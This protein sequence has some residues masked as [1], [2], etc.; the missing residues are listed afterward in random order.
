MNPLVNRISGN[1]WI[2]PVSAMSLV[3]GFMVAL[4]WVTDQ[5]RSSRLNFVSTSQ[6][7]RVQNQAVDMQD[8]VTS[9]QAEVAK[10]RQENTR[11]QNAVGKQNQS[12]RMLNES[13][14]EMK[15]LAGLTDLEGPGV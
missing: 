15:I 14:Q 3:L 10:L 8:A 1:A 2:M 5:T 11:L 12:S 6:R 9:T 7:N 13:L 4:A